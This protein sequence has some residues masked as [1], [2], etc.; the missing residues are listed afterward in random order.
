MHVEGRIAGN[1]EHFVNVE[2]STDHDRVN[3]DTS[4]LQIVGCSDGVECLNVRL[5]VAQNDHTGE[6]VVEV[7]VASIGNQHVVEDAEESTLCV[8]AS[9]SV[10]EVQGRQQICLLPDELVEVDDL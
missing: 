7:P 4:S 9:S 8:G 6:K 1:L 10:V 5:A 3:S 2:V